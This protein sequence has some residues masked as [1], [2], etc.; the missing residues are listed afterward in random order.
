M[1]EE[2]LRRYTDITAPSHILNTTKITLLNPQTWD[3]K[4][5]SYFLG[6]Y[7]KK[8]NLPPC[9]RSVSHKHL[10]RTTTGKLSH[11]DQPEFAF[12]FNATN[13][14]RVAAP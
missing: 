2:S 5:D 11:P 9:W 6:L 14:W 13:C 12:T 4:N 8:E 10:R 1:S 3:D 7:R